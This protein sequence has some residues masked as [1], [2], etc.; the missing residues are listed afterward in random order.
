M[1]N[2]RRL[3]RF[4]R[5]RPTQLRAGVLAISAY[6]RQERGLPWYKSQGHLRVPTWFRRQSEGFLR[7]ARMQK[8]LGLPDEQ[9]VHQ[10]SL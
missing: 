5:V 7:A 1:Q 2:G 9:G 8:Q 4:A 6:V 10:Q 3:Q